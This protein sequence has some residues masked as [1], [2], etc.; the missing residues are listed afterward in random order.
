MVLVLFLCTPTRY[1][2]FSVLNDCIFISPSCMYIYKLKLLKLFSQS[3]IKVVFSVFQS[4]TFSGRQIAFALLVHF[5]FL[6]LLLL[7]FSPPPFRYICLHLFLALLLFIP[8]FILPIVVWIMGHSSGGLKALKKS[9]PVSSWKVCNQLGTGTY[10]SVNK[11]IARSDGETAAAKIIYLQHKVWNN[12][13]F[14]YLTSQS[15]IS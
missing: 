12:M 7:F 9:D 10:G 8:L 14:F 11:V 3:V 4:K 1:C 13:F 5:N 15:I 2:V 6:Y